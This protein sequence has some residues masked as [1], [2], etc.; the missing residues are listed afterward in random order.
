MISATGAVSH[1]TSN[2]PRPGPTMAATEFDAS[3]RAFAS[4]SRSR[5]TSVGMNDWYATGAMTPTKPRMNARP[6]TSL[7]PQNAEDR[8]E[9][10]DRHGR[11]AHE[12]CGDQDPLAPQVDPTPGQQPDEEERDDAD[13]GEGAPISAAVASR[14]MTAVQWAAPAP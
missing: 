5:P 13:R 12:V 8:R 11:R 10:D 3:S 6:A 1:W 4:T 2:P 14:T 9:R 7:A